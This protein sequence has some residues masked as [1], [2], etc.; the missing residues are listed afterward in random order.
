[1]ARREEVESP[2]VVAAKGILV[3]FWL[4]TDGGVRYGYPESGGV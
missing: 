2:Q 1:M 3:V 4:D